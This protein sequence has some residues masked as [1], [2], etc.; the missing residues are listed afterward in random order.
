MLGKV[1]E[2]FRRTKWKSVDQLAQELYSIFIHPMEISPS[3]IVIEQPAGADEPAIE[4]IQDPGVASPAIEITQGSNTVALGGGSSGG[5][6]IDLG[7]VVFP[8][9]DPG[10]TNLSVPEP[11]YNPFVLHGQV[12][13][14][15]SGRV[16]KVRVWA[17]DPAVYPALGIISV[18]FTDVDPDDTIPAGSS[19]PVVAFPGAS[20]STTTIVAARGYVPVFLEPE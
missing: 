15:V 5:G 17:R 18:T 20:G 1:A 14:K 10:D 13:G 6:G 2:R 12:T 9:A 19:T 3:R 4:V 16:Y 8:E 7:E 11:Q